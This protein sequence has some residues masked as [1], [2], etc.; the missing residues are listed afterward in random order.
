MA[1]STIKTQPTL[2][3]KT[4]SYSNITV[5]SA[6]YTKIDSYENLGVS[7]SMYLIS[8]EIRG[9]SGSDV[10]KLVKASNGTDIYAVGTGTYSAFTVEYYFAK[11]VS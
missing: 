11:D 2:L 10:P 8:M 3:K 5:G 7:T 9:W 4:A 1:T 6:G